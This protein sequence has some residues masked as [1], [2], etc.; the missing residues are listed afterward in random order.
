VVAIACFT[1]GCERE[2]WKPEK[3]AYESFSAETASLAHGREAYKTYCVGCHGEMG[4]GSGPAARFLDPKPRDFTSGII[5]FAAVEAGQLPHDEDLRRIIRRGLHGTSMPAWRF[6]PDET[7]DALVAYLKSFAAEEFAADEPHARIV[8]LED[9]WAGWGEAKALDK[10][11]AIYHALALCN[12]C[13][14]SY[15]T[16]PEIAALS[17]K[18]F[19]EAKTS[20]RDD[21]YHGIATTTDWGDEV[22]APDFLTAVLKNGDAVED[23]YRIIVSGVG[24]TAM[25]TWRGALPEEDLWALAYYVQSVA[26]LRSTDQA[27]VL[28]AKFADQA[29]LAPR[30]VVPGVEEN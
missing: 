1:T 12:N 13:H 16:R 22:I 25:P 11:A 29:P 26:A 21:M 9:P 27:R 4:D 5:K 30:A 18:H 15:L 19:G 8:G 3:L 17:K 7:V 24:G 20:F 2:D 23:L 10:G 6:M 28:A 14:P